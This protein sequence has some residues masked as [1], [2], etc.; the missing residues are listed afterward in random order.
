M[1][2]MAYIPLS[3]RLA[4]PGTRPPVP[5]LPYTPF[6]VTEQQ[7]YELRIAYPDEL[8][9]LTARPLPAAVSM[10]CALLASA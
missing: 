7:Y 5:A 9:N 3:T 4:A 1:K 8:V 2:L 10:A 6:K